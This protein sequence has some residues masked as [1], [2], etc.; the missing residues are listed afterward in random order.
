MS[1]VKLPETMEELC[2]YI[3]LYKGDIYVREQVDGKWGAFALSE[4]PASKAL[5]HALRFVK[6]GR[7]PT[8]ILRS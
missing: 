8:R 7:V 5:G 1:E 2:D 4:L 6:E 3:L